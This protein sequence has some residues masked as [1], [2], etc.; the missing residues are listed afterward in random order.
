[1]IQSR[2]QYTYSAKGRGVNISAYAGHE[3]TCLRGAK[4]AQMGT[5]VPMMLYLQKQIGCARFELRAL[6]CQSL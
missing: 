5:S 4:T 3:V 2:A 6:G 1:M